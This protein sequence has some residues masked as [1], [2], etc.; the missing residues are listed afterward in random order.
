MTLVEPIATTTFITVLGVFQVTCE[1]KRPKRYENIMTN[2]LV[3]RL[4][5]VF[6]LPMIHPIE[7]YKIKIKTAQIIKG[8]SSR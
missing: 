6:L 4:E 8:R 7:T 1:N 5:R 2:V 3:W